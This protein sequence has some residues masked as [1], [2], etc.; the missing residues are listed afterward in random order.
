MTFVEEHIHW[1]GIYT[2]ANKVP[3][4]KVRLLGRKILRGDDQ[5]SV[6]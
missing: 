4:G 6:S 2:V 3:L 5:S 1:S